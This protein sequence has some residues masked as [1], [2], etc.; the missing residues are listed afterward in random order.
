M[1]HRFCPS[2][3]GA[4]LIAIL[5]ATFFTVNALAP[6]LRPLQPPDPIIPS[7]GSQGITGS[8][9]VSAGITTG[10]SSGTGSVTIDSDA[11]GNPE[12]LFKDQGTTDFRLRYDKVKFG[13]FDASNPV[14]TC[15]GGTCTATNNGLTAEGSLK[16]DAFIV[17]DSTVAGDAEL[18]FQDAGV[19]RFTLFWDDDLET[20]TLT[21]TSAGVKNGFKFERTTGNWTFG[22]GANGETW[23]WKGTDGDSVLSAAG[24]GTFGDGADS[25][26]TTTAGSPVVVSGAAPPTVGQVLTA[27][28][29]TAATWQS[30][31]ANSDFAEATVDTTETS[32]TFVDLLTTTITT[33]ASDILINASVSSSNASNN[34][35]HDFRI[36]IDAVVQRGFSSSHGSASLNGQGSGIVLRRSVTAATHTIKLQW[37][38]SSGTAQIR[39]V[40]APDSEHASLYVEEL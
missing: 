1:K 29:A 30:P 37:Q 14:F 31:A 9:D 2:T 32:S 11:F 34:K 6:D 36:L 16:G 12:I 23:T 19:T 35:V 15:S 38:V 20:L 22:N 8:L 24:R 13:F 28:G 17:V 10:S 3:Y 18:Q 21:R 25:F 27:T 5:A 4:V 26:T 39:P 33:G 40:A 7:D